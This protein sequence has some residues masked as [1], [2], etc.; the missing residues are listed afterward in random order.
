[1]TIA[2][3][4]AVVWYF[5]GYSFAFALSMGISVLVIS[6]PC[7]LGLATP[8]AIMVGT[9]KGAENGILIKSAEAL[10]TA[11]TINAIVLDKTGTITQGKPRVVAI[12]PAPGISEQTL[13]QAAASI[14]K[15]SEHPLADA[16][17]AEA[18]R[19]QLRLSDVSDFA[20]I[21]GQG[22]SAVIDGKRYL[23]GNLKLMAD[24][25]ID[26]GDL[27]AKGS[28]CARQGQTPLYFAADGKAL[29]LISAADTIKPTSAQAITD[30]KNLGLDVVMLTGDN[31]RTAEAIAQQVGITEIEAE[32][33]P[34]DKAQVV[35]KLQL[36]GKKVAMV[37]DGIND[38]PA[39]AQADVG[40][41]I[42]AGTDVAIE[43]ADIVLMKSDLLDACGAIRLSKAVIRNIKQNLFWA[44][45]YNSIGIP[46][47]AG[48][49]FLPLGLKLN[50]MFA[51]AAMSLSSV[52][53]VTNALRLKRFR[54]PFAPTDTCPNLPE[55]AAPAAAHPI[56]TEPSKG[57][58]IMNKTM[59]VD[60]MTC[61][62]CSARVEKALNAID[63]VEAHVDLDSKTAAITLTKEVA[64]E[65]LAKAVTDADYT[66]VSIS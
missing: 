21:V 8:V 44:F 60:G 40:V 2:L 56:Q 17:V 51:A 54:T 11:H 30:F 22:I 31:V 64:D 53:V 10:E 42:G 35:K 47:A 4:T 61:P 29:G 6:C 20:A 48:L 45:F 18:A 14:E 49:L 39:L 24:A 16:I 28:D 41:A 63:G 1:M 57:E 12:E 52:C 26:F 50:P 62:H 34:Q 19:R 37:G 5:L 46:L 66:V 43:S 33:L 55:T 13:L 36:A 3:L 65:V 27:A 9:G 58:M 59:I 38:A 25:H 15:P 23:A 32:V 7:A